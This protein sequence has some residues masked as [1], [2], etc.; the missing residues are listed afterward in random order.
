VVTFHGALATE[1]PAQKGKVRARVLVL[2]GAAD[3]FVPPAQVNAFKQEMK[4]AG[5]RYEVISYPGAKH[6]FTNP[7]A[8]KYGMAAAR[9]QRRRRPQVVGEDAR[10][11]QEDLALSADSRARRAWIARRN[12]VSRASFGSRAGAPRAVLGAAPVVNRARDLRLDVRQRAVHASLA[13]LE[14]QRL[15]RVRGGV[16]VR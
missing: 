11:V 9:L 13:D 8:G 15:H 5:A 14:Q 7:D 6:S 10:A 16:D 2:A 12:R 3:P 1:R 4:T